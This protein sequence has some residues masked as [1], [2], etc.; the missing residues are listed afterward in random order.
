MVHTGGGI[1]TTSEGAHEVGRENI[2]DH[3]TTRGKYYRLATKKLTD[4]RQRSRILTDNRLSNEILTDMWTP[5]FRPS[6]YANEIQILHRKWNLEHS[7]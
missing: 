3:D 5:P 2:T 1:T 7:D 6:H 4:N